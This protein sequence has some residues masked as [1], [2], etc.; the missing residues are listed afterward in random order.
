MD[1]LGNKR[2]PPRWEDGQELPDLWHGL[3]PKSQ[4]A[5]AVSCFWMQLLWFI[6]QSWGRKQYVPL[7]G[8]QTS[9]RLHDVT[10]QRTALLTEIGI[11]NLKS[12][13]VRSWIITMEHSFPWGLY[14]TP[15]F[16]SAS[17]CDSVCG[18]DTATS[19][20]VAV[21]RPDEVINFF[22]QFY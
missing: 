17:L 20:K 10:S 4:T 3:D 22:F 13:R 12:S 5:A 1:L 21:S 8:Q 14:H 2:G 11:K 7:K 19:R 6:L 15:D 9:T 18:W 16:L